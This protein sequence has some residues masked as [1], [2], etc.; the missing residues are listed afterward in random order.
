MRRLICAVL[1]V[2]LLAAAAACS[3]DSSSAQ[4]QQPQQQITE[5]TAEPSAGA[6]GENTQQQAKPAVAD[7]D[8]AQAVA[9]PDAEQQAL[10]AEPV[11]LT[12]RWP[13]DAWRPLRRVAEDNAALQPEIDREIEWCRESV[14]RGWANDG[15]HWSEPNEDGE[16]VRLAGPA[17]LAADEHP[18]IALVAEAMAEERGIALETMPAVWLAS[19]EW[20]RAEVC[21]AVVSALEGNRIE[22]P[23]PRWHLLTALGI[24]DGG[25][26]P[27]LLGHLG[28][29]LGRYEPQRAS[30]RGGGGRITLL[31]P[32]P[33]NAQTASVLAHEM[34]HHLQYQLIG[35]GDADVW[36]PHGTHDRYAMLHWLIEADATLTMSATDSAAFQAAIAL[37]SGGGASPAD[38]VNLFDRLPLEWSEPFY[39]PYRRAEAFVGRLM[40]WGIPD[41]INRMLRDLPDSTEQLLHAAKYEADEQPLDL[42][43]LQPL[44]DAAISDE[45]TRPGAPLLVD[46]RDQDTLGELYLRLLISASTGREAEASAAAAGWGGDRLHIFERDDGGALVVWAI[47]FDDEAEHAEGVNGLREWLIA[48]SEGQ[49]WGIGGERML[50][51]DAPHGAIRVLN[52]LNTAWLLAAPDAAAVDAVAAALLAADA[53]IGWWP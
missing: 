27:T 52:Q 32:M 25:W 40:S 12:A 47:A 31:T 13:S 36:P 45:W 53:N 21:R 38:D 51:W 10:S 30:Q 2:V 19:P 4:Q 20:Q 44:I 16:S 26:G 9:A 6:A 33:P 29:E 11:T 28:L 3:G 14:E 17:L 49:A 1:G 37:L 23:T 34:V 15:G 22:R 48:F 24:N 35:D 39:G 18:W 43:S 8:D 42:S 41:V 50:G 46:G 7:P 5:Q